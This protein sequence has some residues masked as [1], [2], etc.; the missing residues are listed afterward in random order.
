MLPPGSAGDACGEHG[1]RH[2]LR[3]KKTAQ[4]FPSLACRW[5]LLNDIQQPSPEAESG[6]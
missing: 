3:P 4:H 1:S 5:A 2:C 6:P